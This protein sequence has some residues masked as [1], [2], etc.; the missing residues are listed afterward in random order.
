M[1][2]LNNE[3]IKKRFLEID[4]AKGVAVMSMMFFH[5][6]LLRKLHES[7]NIFPT[8]IGILGLLATISHSTF[9]LASGANLAISIHN[10]IRYIPKKTKRGLNLLAT[11]LI[12]SS[13]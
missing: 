11:G 4:L 3:H 1:N 7:L 10:K 13:I 9:I 12:I 5:Y 2:Y 8:S 6:F